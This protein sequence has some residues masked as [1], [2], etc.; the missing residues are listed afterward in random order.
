MRQKRHSFDL[1]LVL[2]I[3]CVY[4]AG[5]L[6]LC[7]VGANTYKDISAVMQSNYDLRTGVL[8]LTEKTRQNDVAGAISVQK[9]GD[10]DALVLV[11]QETG[12]GYETWIFVHEGML[13]EELIFSGSKVD[14]NMLQA[15]MPMQSMKLTLDENNILSIKLVGADGIENSRMLMLKAQ[16]EPFNYDPAAVALTAA[17]DAVEGD[18]DDLDED[19]LE[20]NNEDNDARGGGGR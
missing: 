19:E 10:V 4:A 7:V 6:F 3:F 9:V 14:L 12:L 1:L 16:G 5:A 20:E 2:I 11:E 8:Y 17:V 15:I 13:C 18:F